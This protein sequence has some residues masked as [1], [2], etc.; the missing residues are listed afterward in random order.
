M[1]C[2]ARFA[3]A[4][5]RGLRARSAWAALHAARRRKSLFW[6]RVAVGAHEQGNTQRV[7]A[8]QH[9]EG[10]KG[11]RAKRNGQ[12]SG[13]GWMLGRGMEELVVMVLRSTWM[14]RWLCED[15]GRRR[16]FKRRRDVKKINRCERRE[17]CACTGRGS[18]STMQRRS[19]ARPSRH[20]PSHHRAPPW[21]NKC[22]HVAIPE[23]P[24]VRRRRR[25]GIGYELCSMV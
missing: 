2:S 16:L 14:C 20:L 21:R 4:F 24:M 9:T 18:E 8:E 3:R 13:A 22:G 6:L 11:V 19:I 10:R 7:K 1:S 5:P 15:E 25:D 17:S 12:R 23:F